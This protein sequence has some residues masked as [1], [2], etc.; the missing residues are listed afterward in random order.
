MHI[1]IFEMKL[2]SSTEIVLCTM[3]VVLFPSICATD[4]A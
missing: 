3:H 1:A 4:F 2:H